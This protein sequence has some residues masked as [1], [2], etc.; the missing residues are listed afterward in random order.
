MF[1]FMLSW[2]LLFIIRIKEQDEEELRQVWQ[3]K[4]SIKEEA[5]H[6]IISHVSGQSKTVI[7]CAREKVSESRKVVLWVGIDLC[8]KLWVG[9]WYE[10]SCG[11]YCTRMQ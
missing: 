10:H 2:K 6:E 7:F 11:E 1:S 5:K 9:L 3:C 8:D 4:I